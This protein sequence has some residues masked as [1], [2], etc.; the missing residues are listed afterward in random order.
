MAQFVNWYQVHHS[1]V[2][3]NLS[4]VR[5][6]MQEYRNSFLCEASFAGG[7]V[8]GTNISQYQENDKATSSLEKH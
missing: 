7:L 8:T 2:M 1:L 3:H 6:E 5:L 4:E